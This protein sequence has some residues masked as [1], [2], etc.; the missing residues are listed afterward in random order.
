[1]SDIEGSQF[2]YRLN[3]TN[4]DSLENFKESLIKE[5]DIEKVNVVFN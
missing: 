3:F 2:T 5:K 4:K 1:M